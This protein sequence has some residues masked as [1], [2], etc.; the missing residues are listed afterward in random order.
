[1]MHYVINVVT[2][3]LIEELEKKAREAVDKYPWEKVILV[4]IETW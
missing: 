1:M 2:D 3:I 4:Y